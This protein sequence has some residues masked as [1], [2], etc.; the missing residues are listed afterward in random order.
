MVGLLG[1]ELPKKIRYGRREV[2]QVNGHLTKIFIIVLDGHY[3]IERQ[4]MFIISLNKHKAIT[5]NGLRLT[6]KKQ[7]QNKNKKA[8]IFYEYCIIILNTAFSD[9]KHYWL[10]AKVNGVPILICFVIAILGIVI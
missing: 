9:W 1:E 10:G 4:K 3:F 5:I 8:K 6:K 7:K 2:E